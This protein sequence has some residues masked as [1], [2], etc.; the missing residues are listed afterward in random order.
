MK[1]MSVDSAVGEDD[2]TPFRNIMNEWY[3]K[4]LSRKLRSA[5]RAKSAQGYALGQ[6]PLH[7]AR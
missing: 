4:D 5:Q 6:P 1:P 7:Q 2:F 3:L